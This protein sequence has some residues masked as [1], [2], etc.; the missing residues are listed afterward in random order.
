[1]HRMSLPLADVRWACCAA[2]TRWVLPPLG[3]FMSDAVLMSWPPQ[4]QTACLN[5][6]TVLNVVGVI[7]AVA[8]R[9]RA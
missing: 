2:S 5:C 7:T 3:P 9:V 1:M 4:A 8:L 6:M